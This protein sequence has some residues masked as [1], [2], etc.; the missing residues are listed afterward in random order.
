MVKD[1]SQSKQSEGGGDSTVNFGKYTPLRTTV[2]NSFSYG[3]EVV[4]AIDNLSP[5]LHTGHGNLY[6]SRHGPGL[7]LE[8]DSRHLQ[9]ADVRFG[10]ILAR[11]GPNARRNI[12]QDRLILGLDS[13]H[14]P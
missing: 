5:H 12:Q 11:I 2:R 14:R 9:Y 8:Y 4:P 10:D 3:G 1:T 13:L 6:Y 7:R